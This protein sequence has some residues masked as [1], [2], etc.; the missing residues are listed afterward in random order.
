MHDRRTALPCPGLDVAIRRACVALAYHTRSGAALRAMTALPAHPICKCSPAPCSAGTL[1]GRRTALPRPD[2]ATELSVRPALATQAS[3]TRWA[4]RLPT[5][6]R[7]HCANAPCPHHHACG[8]ALS[9]CV[10]SPAPCSAG[11]LRGRLS[12][13][14]PRLRCVASATLH[15]YL[16]CAHAGLRR[17]WITCAQ[18]RTPRARP[19]APQCGALRRSSA[20]VSRPR[21]QPSPRPSP[22]LRPS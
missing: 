14:L 19:R 9:L 4:A 18:T 15:L 2:Q 17:N 21:S 20:G 5:T 3:W 8:T 22:R 1:H 10:C 11:T 12:A 16:L 13:I 7:T 6:P